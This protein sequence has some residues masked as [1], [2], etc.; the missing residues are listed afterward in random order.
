MTQWEYLILD[1]PEITEI[2]LDDMGKHGWEA[3]GMVTG[4]RFLM[5]RPLRD[6]R[7]GMPII[8]EPH[9]PMPPG[10]N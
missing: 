4:Y 9:D 6:D 7:M 2:H 1:E 8:P 5:K 10:P 3:V